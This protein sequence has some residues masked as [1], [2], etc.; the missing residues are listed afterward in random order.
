[1]LRD[2]A[3]EPHATGSA[4]WLRPDLATFEVARAL[5]SIASLL[6]HAFTII[7]RNLSGPPLI[8]R[9]QVLIS[10][11]SDPARLGGSQP[12]PRPV[13]RWLQFLR[14]TRTLPSTVSVHGPAVF[15]SGEMVPPWHRARRE[16]IGSTLLYIRYCPDS[17]QVLHR[18]EMTR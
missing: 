2:Q 10:P 11:R 7:P 17:E 4:K 15:M 8:A 18:T 3:L 9:Q 14:A 6:V 5:G 13:G 16:L 1:M 12:G